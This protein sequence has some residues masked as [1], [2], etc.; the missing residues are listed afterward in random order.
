MTTHALSTATRDGVNLRYLDTGSGDRPLVFIHGWCC[1]H[2]YWRDQTTEFARRHRV[3]AVDLR[4]HGQSDKP[5]QDYTI[6]G[7]A[8]D[9]AWLIRRLDLD[10]PV[11]VGHSMGGVIAL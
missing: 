11:L 5:D 10:R 9:V 4:G 1:D 2:T 6:G 8:D 7:F 3:I